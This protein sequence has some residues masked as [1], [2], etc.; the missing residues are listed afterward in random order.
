VG[1]RNE[2]I[3]KEERREKGRRQH[4]EKEGETCKM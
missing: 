1:N 3:K 2:K 4:Q